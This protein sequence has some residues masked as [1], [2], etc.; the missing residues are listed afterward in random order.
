M[1]T[2]FL[3]NRGVF[4]DD[5]TIG[6]LFK[7]AEFLCYTLENTVRKKRGQLAIPNGMYP[8]VID[9]SVKFK[10]VMPHILNVPGFE[11]IRIHSGNTEADT[12]GCIL[13]GK[14]KYENYIG[15]S[16]KAYSEFMT[17]FESALKQG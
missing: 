15:E 9:Y 4:T 12:D 17:K 6:E 1:S 8:M 16:R 5:S 13:V 11:G 3:L 14:K 7:G 2:I 10:R